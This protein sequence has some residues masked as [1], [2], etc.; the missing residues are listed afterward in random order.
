MGKRSRVKCPNDPNHVL[1]EYD[2]RY[3]TYACPV[4]DIWAEDACDSTDEC[5]FQC[6]TR[7]A[8]PSLAGPYI[9]WTKR[10]CCCG[11]LGSAHNYNCN[12]CTCTTFKESK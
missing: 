11:H 12:E 9:P 3:D 8:K 5:H 4:C 1:S 7:P 2:G 10:S 6:S